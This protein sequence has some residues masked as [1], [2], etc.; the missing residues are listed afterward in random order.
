M[1][2]RIVAGTKDITGTRFGKLIAVCQ[3]G[4]TERGYYEWEC[5]C[6]CGG[7]KVVA[8]TRLMQGN[9]QSCGCSG[10]RK[11]GA[12]KRAAP[13]TLTRRSWQNMLNR[14][15]NA[16][17]PSFS[18]Y[19]ERGITVCERW[20]N[21][22]DAFIEDMGHRP[23]AA[24]TIDRIDNN[25]GYHKGNCRWATRAEQNRNT[26][27]VVW[28]EWNGERMTQSEWAARIGVH[29][30]TIMGRRRKGLPIELVLAP[31]GLPRGK[32]AIQSSR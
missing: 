2:S 6:D 32:S 29:E 31:R 13:R 4:K 14:C 17:S 21:S 7:R 3:L 5:V 11:P 10:G 18:D 28:I 1:S 26:R 23:S 30:T 25:D 8:V 16:S 24:H 12:G 27:H 19:G 9:V 15:R 22:L 20:T